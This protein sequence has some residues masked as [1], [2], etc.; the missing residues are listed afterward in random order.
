LAV[1]K[2]ALYFV[3]ALEAGINF[4]L[5]SASINGLGNSASIFRAGK[6]HEDM[7]A[8]AGGPRVEW[9]SCP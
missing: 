4:R 9:L 8:N 2:L 5:R 3:G 7:D 6:I 1:E